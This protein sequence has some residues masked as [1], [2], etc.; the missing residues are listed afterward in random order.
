GASVLGA[1]AVPGAASPVAG[2]AVRLASSGAGARGSPSGGPQVSSQPPPPAPPPANTGLVQLLNEVLLLIGF[3]GVLQPANQDVLLWGK[4]PTILQ[5]LAEVPFPYFVEQQLYQ[6]LM[7]TLLSVCYGSERACATLAQHMDL[8][9]LQS[10]VQTMIRQLHL[11]SPQSANAAEHQGGAAEQDCEQASASATHGTAVTGIETQDSSSSLPCA[12]TDASAVEVTGPAPLSPRRLLLQD[13]PTTVPGMSGSGGASSRANPE[14]TLVDGAHAPDSILST[15]AEQA[16]GAAVAAGSDVF[17]LPPPTADRYSLLQRFPPELLPQVLAFLERQIPGAVERASLLESSLAAAVAAA[18][19]VG[20]L[21]AAPPQLSSSPLAVLVDEGRSKKAASKKAVATTPA[22]ATVTQAVCSNDAP[23]QLPHPT[24]EAAASVTIVV[25]SV[26][27]AEAPICCALERGPAAVVVAAPSDAGNN[28]A[29]TRGASGPSPPEDENV[30][31]PFSKAGS[32]TVEDAASGIAI[33]S[34]PLS[35]GACAVGTGSSGRAGSSGGSLGYGHQF[36]RFLDVADVPVPFAIAAV[37]RQRMFEAAAAAAVA[38]VSAGGGGSGSV[39]ANNCAR[40]YVS[41]L[42]FGGYLTPSLH[43]DSRDGD[44]RSPGED[45]RMALDEFDLEQY[46]QQRLD[47]Q[48]QL[49]EQDV[50]LLDEPCVDGSAGSHRKASLSAA[51]TGCKH[52]DSSGGGKSGD[53]RGSSSPPDLG[54]GLLLAAKKTK[55]RADRHVLECE[56]A[57]EVRPGDKYAVPEST[58][59]VMDA[60]WRR[61]G[62]E[63]G[64]ARD[65][66]NSESAPD[67]ADRE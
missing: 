1:V 39:D 48:Q 12:D 4:S 62:Y 32:V 15:H 28:P 55:G 53:G 49:D 17:A 26:A 11:I 29:E 24:A 35:N 51:E 8:H 59:V 3:Y 2:P 18:A 37:R 21:T 44:P 63:F 38:E 27:P 41:E 67:E 46:E 23:L 19:A 60:W 22:P 56:P 42:S 20:R 66:S 34:Q 61:I 5:R 40:S 31:T 7:P 25:S 57:P 30:L 33:D 45:D 47:E 43:G 16:G 36:R 54:A 14:H 13:L 58:G 10:Y 6:V 65:G 9:L 50:L 64:G 52:T